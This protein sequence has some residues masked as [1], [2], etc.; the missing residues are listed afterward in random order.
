MSVAASQTSV[1]QV[2]CSATPFGEGVVE[3]GGEEGPGAGDAHDVLAVCG[4]PADVRGRPHEL[5]DHHV[6][7]RRGLGRSTASDFGWVPGSIR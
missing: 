3:V 5:L 7:F 4:G 2:I 1:G 6:G